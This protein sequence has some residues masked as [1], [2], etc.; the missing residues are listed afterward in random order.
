MSKILAVSDIHIND[1]AQRNPTN[2]FR[3]YQG[4]RTVA[5]NII[6]VGRREGCDIIVL[7]GDITEKSIIRPYIQAEIKLFL[8]TVMSAFNYGFLILGNHDLDNKGVEQDI[9][10]ACLGVMLPGN[11]Y[12]AHQKTVDIDGTRFGFSNWMPEFDLSW[13]DNKVDVLFTHA[14]I[15]Y[16]TGDQG[17]LFESQKLDESKFD[18]AICG[19]IHRAAQLG[20]YVSIGVPQKC[21]MGD[22]DEATGIVLDCQNKSWSWVN[23][24]PHDN[25]MRFAYTGNLDYEGWHEDDHTWYVYKQENATINSDG[26]IRLD[27]QNEINTMIEEAIIQSNLQGVHTEVLKNIENIEAGEVDFNFT[28]LR[29][30]CENWR[31]IENADLCFSPGDRILVRGFNGTGKSS[32]LTAL[33]YAFVDVSDTTGLSS[34][35]P[36]VQFGKKDCYTEVT[37]LYQGNECR[38]LRGT[39]NYEHSIN[40]EL[41]RYNDKRSFEKDL[42]NRYPFIEYLDAF[43][44]D[45]GNNQ[46]LGS[47]SPERETEITS[48]FLKLDRIETYNKTATLLSETFRKEQQDKMGQK[49]ELE[50]LLSYIN[51]KLNSISIP[52]ISK[53]ELERLKSEGLELQRKN[54]LWNQYQSNTISLQAQIQSAESRLTELRGRQFREDNIINQEETQAHERIKLLQQRQVELGNLRTTLQYKKTEYE[55]LRREGNKA[56]TDAQ[57]LGLGR[58]CSLCGQPIQNTEA[59]EKHKEELLKKV[60]ELRP[61]IQELGQEIQQGEQEIQTSAEEYNALNMEIRNLNSVI[62]SCITEKTEKLRTQSEI[63]EWENRREKTIEM[64]GN[65]GAPEKVDLPPDFMTKM[66]EIESSLTAWGIYETN[67]SD[68]YKKEG[69]LKQIEAELQNTQNALGELDAYIKL[70]G[71]TGAV[72]EAVMQKLAKDFSDNQISYSVVRKGK[73]NREH[74]NLVPNYNNGKNHVAYLACSSGQKCQCDLHFLS[75]LITSLG[76]ICFDEFLKNLD[77]ERTEIA[78]D[79]IKNLPVG[80]VFLTSHLESVGAQ[81][82]NKVLD[83]ELNSQGLTQ[84]KLC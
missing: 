47:L 4:S 82:N 77:A 51:D 84:M 64:L 2:R 80:C 48:K 46:F 9:S 33:K 81:F 56:W 15:C 54:T 43:F 42:R 66:A 16:A 13:I 19:D 71:P 45:A 63:K 10:D 17:G 12:Y 61:R 7:A 53:S 38:I 18:L 28:L 67:A 20:K 23:L 60:E 14:R 68:K 78:L 21:K 62:S 31:S 35:K 59:M 29:L 22:S 11:L 25:L 44:F 8:D 27:A 72:Y 57:N 30:R 24:N 3:L 37:F 69:E 50:R 36:F 40:G 74:L 6:E 49:K 55:N 65:L 26:S 76:V 79:L 52:S 75:R 32:I 83:M 1:Y 39:K 58:K 73:G 5:Q 41:Q 70:M 34:L